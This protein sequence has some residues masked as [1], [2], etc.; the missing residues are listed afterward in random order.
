MATLTHSIRRSD[1]ITAIV[2]K[3]RTRSGQGGSF[4]KFFFL[5]GQNQLQLRPAN[6]G[7]ANSEFGCTFRAGLVFF[8]GK[9]FHRPFYHS[10]SCFIHDY[11]IRT[12]S[13]QFRGIANTRTI[14]DIFSFWI[15]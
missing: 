6:R 1:T 4:G 8:S 9:V 5:I 7:P 13:N 15:E 10:S 12:I 14:I 2:E 11:I 3:V